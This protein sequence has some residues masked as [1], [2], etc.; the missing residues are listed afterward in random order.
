MKRQPHVKVNNY[1]H[2]HGEWKLP[3]G[4]KY[5]D[6]SSREITKALENAERRIFDNVK[7]EIEAKGAVGCDQENYET[8]KFDHLSAAKPSNDSADP[9][10]AEDAKN[11][12]DA[13]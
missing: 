8:N 13:E 7:E 10:E 2:K 5:P 11:P 12:D 4:T 3:E 6:E 1:D 9:V